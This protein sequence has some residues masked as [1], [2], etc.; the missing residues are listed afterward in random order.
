[1]TL[2]KRKRDFYFNV[3]HYVGLV[4]MVCGFILLLPLLYLLFNSGE[5]S[6]SFGF[7]LPAIAMMIIGLVI[8]L[9]IKPVVKS[10]FSITQSQFVVVISWIIVCIFSTIPFIIIE[11]MSMLHALFESVSGWTTTGLTL[12]DTSNCST[13]ILLWRSIMQ[14]FGG[15]GLAII[16]L[17]T[18]LG[19]QAPTLGVAEGRSTQ[20]VPNVIHSSTI[21][22]TLYLSYAIA[23]IVAYNLSGMG[24]FDSINHTLTAISTGGF[25]TKNASIGYWNSLSINIVTMILM[26]LGNLNFLTIYLLIHGKFK[27]LFKNSE[28][29][30]LS[31]IVIVCVVLFYFFVGRSL[32]NGISERIRIS[33]FEVISA[34]TTTG[35]TSTT[36]SGWTPFAFFMMITLMLIGGGTCSTAGGIKQYRIF[37]LFKSTIWE[38]KKMLL[39]KKAVVE[40]YIWQ[41]EN[42]EYITSDQIRRIS[43]FFFL[44]ISTFIIGSGLICLHGYSIQNSLFEFASALGTVGLSV[45]ITSTSAPIGVLWIEILGMFLGRL[46]FIVILVTMIKFFRDLFGIN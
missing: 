10:S 7:F 39:P 42:K 31:L 17:A 28:I 37:V 23:G 18:I 21:V 34:I 24:L 35:F 41:G 22:L 27:A 43:L 19:P 9:K 4:L 29:K 16:M 5:I 25:S 26:I 40:N 2:F 45:G 11:K 12:V 32:Y 30:T 20:L 44:Y 13:M 8:W 15:A 36:Y 38:L 33:L 1:M 46:E 6:N 14:F 3:L